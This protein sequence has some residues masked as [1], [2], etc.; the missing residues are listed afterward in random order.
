[1]ILGRLYK[2]KKKTAL[3][4]QHLSKA[5]LIASQYGQTPMLARIDAALAELA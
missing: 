4:V 3:A 5:K 1:M 2:T